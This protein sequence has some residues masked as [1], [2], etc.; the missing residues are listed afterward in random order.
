[1]NE[2][3]LT[4]LNLVASWMIRAGGWLQ[5]QGERLSPRSVPKQ[6]L[7]SLTTSVATIAYERKRV[8]QLGH[9]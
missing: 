8:C 3:N 7:E 5:V 2:R 1:M 6:Q 9:S 4:M